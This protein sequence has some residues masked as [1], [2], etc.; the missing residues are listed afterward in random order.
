MRL[1][2]WFERFIKRFFALAF[3]TLL[4][5]DPFA[6]THGAHARSGIRRAPIKLDRLAQ[7]KHV[8][9]TKIAAP[10]QTL[11]FT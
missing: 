5:E 6:C 1:R 2:V 9:Q 7:I 3:Q 4:G 11:K 8:A 10:P